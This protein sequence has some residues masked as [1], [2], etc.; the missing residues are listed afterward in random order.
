ML[1]IG[2]LPS[3]AI[4]KPNLASS[5]TGWTSFAGSNGSF[6]NRE[7]A[8]ASVALAGVIMIVYPSG[9]E[10]ARYSV[11]ML[12]CAPALLTTITGLPASSESF[13]L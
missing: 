12:P 1:R 10:R 3:T 8:A 13:A 9:L 2:L 6:L 7:A 11:A 5:T 4:T